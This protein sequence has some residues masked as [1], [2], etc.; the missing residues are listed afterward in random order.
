MFLVKIADCEGKKSKMSVL[1]TFEQNSY[2]VFDLD[3]P[4][5]LKPELYEKPNFIFI[6]SCF[7]NDPMVI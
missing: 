4:V 5:I 3:L 6:F 1:F 7:C 2:H